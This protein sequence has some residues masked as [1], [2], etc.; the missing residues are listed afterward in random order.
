M[1]N[2]NLIRIRIVQIVYSWYQNK[3]KDL[4]SLEKE[5][6]FGLKK[7]YD[8]YY[9][10]LL[11][12]IEIT[13]AYEAKVE[14]RRNKLLPTE[15]DLNPNMKLINNA[16]IRQLEQNKQLIKYL[17]DYPMSWEDHDS[18]VKKLLEEILASDIYLNYSK[19]KDSSY[20]ADKEFWRQVFRNFIHNNEVLD[21]ILE[22]ESIYWNDDIET[23]QSF[24]LKTIRQF[25]ESAGE[26]QQLLPMFKNF[27][28]KSFALKLLHNTILNQD[29]YR[30]LIESHTDKWDFDRIAFMDLIIMQ[31]AIAEIH[32]FDDIP[33]SVSMNEYIEL[34]KSYSTPKSGTFINGV[35]DAIVNTLK[36]DSVIF[37][38]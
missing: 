30:E 23:I 38:T 1:I 11:L 5:L 3:N 9:Y 12:M 13:K 21:D 6:L 36:K 18:F 14:T 10:L 24:T 31:V 19:E 2:R 17:N 32:T 22:D 15:E 20:D 27:E 26:D 28:D 4:R 35:L 29:K 25:S 33:T 37:K 34:S 7:S 16:F 8:L